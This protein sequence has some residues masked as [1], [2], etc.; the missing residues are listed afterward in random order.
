MGGLAPWKNYRAWMVG[1]VSC[2]G[3]PIL[4]VQVMDCSCRLLLLVK[5]FL[6]KWII[7]WD[8]CLEWELP[9]DGCAGGGAGLIWLFVLLK[10]GEEVGCPRVALVDGSYRVKH[11]WCCTV[12]GSWAQHPHILCRSHPCFWGNDDP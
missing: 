2:R 8:G 6:D 10:N 11:F 1:W 3:R 5:H 4:W 7:R 12:A 9:R